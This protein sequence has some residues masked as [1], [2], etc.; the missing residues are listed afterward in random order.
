MG[1]SARPP[2]SMPRGAAIAFT[3]A[4]L[5]MIAATVLLLA[6]FAWQPW[7]EDASGGGVQGGAGTPVP[8]Q[9][10]ILPAR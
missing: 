10:R 9:Q 6:L 5:T 7:H 8:E 4:I 2:D 1:A 3:A